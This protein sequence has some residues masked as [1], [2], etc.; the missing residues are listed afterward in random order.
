MSLQLRR[1]RDGLLVVSC[2]RSFF[3][4][5]GGCFWRI[6]LWKRG[7]EGDLSDEIPPDPPFPKGGTHH[8]AS[9]EIILG[10][11]P[12][13]LLVGSATAIAETPEEKGLQIAEEADRRVDAGPTK[14]EGSPS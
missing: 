9:P 13:L 2:W 4:E 12:L 5:S 6:P 14:K 10:L 11:V 7:T 8:W 1:L 3:T